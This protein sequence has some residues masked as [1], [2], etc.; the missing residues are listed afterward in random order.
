VAQNNERT[1]TLKAKGINSMLQMKIILTLI[2]I[3]FW[4]NSF[5]Q[6]KSEFPIVKSESVGVESRK[7]DTISNALKKWFVDGEIVG[8]EILIIKN[9]KTILH[10]SIGWRDREDEES[11]SNN[12]ICRIRSMTKPIIGTVIL[13][14]IDKGKLS[15]D[16]KVSKYINSFGNEKSCEITIQQLLT[17]TS[18]LENSDY[19]NYVGHATDY[20]SL[21]QYVDTIGK[22]GPIYKP[23]TQYRYS[24][25]GTSVLTYL[26]SIVSGMPA[27]DY[28]KKQIFAPL[29]LSDTFCSLNENND[30]RSRLSST[31]EIGDSSFIKYWDNSDP[32]EL[33]YFR[34]S[35]GIYSTTTDYAKFITLWMNFGKIENKEYISAELIKRALVPTALND[36]YAFH[37]SIYNYNETD[38]PKYLPIFHHGGSDGTFAAAI[39]EQDMIVLYFTQS[40]GNKTEY[41]L[42]SMIIKEFIGR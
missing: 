11:F 16:D 3:S 34:G 42:T 9:Q 39:P 38:T 26:I 7:L 20:T 27:E 14:L 8:G 4:S 35:G 21:K 23:G 13:L 41:K 29:N 10:E 18:G 25:P 36:D 40:R 22:Y 33:A 28:I 30:K 32:Q 6:S 31:Y 15:L 19:P 24:D 12:T 17:H 1:Q 2:L 37:W 5:S